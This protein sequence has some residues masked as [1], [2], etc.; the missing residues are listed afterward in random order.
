MRAP[1][2]LAILLAGLVA[3]A[4]PAAA[5]DGPAGTAKLYC[6]D[7]G[8]SALS[9]R[10]ATFADMTAAYEEKVGWRHWV[11][12]VSP[13]AFKIGFSPNAQASD[14]E[15]ATFEVETH[16]D[17]IIVNAVTYRFEGE[18]EQLDAGLICLRLI[19]LVG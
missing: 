12:P 18:V 15:S 3:S 10:R 13:T 14:A 19:N 5:S 11:E 4:G 17:G 6:R 1:G 8:G 9:L 16:Q 2:L 7:A